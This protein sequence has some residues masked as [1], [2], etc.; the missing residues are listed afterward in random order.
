MTH[1]VAILAPWTAGEWRVV[2]PDAPEC[3]AIANSP[4]EAVFAAAVKV[5]RRVC[6][7]GIDQTTPRDLLA[8]ATD[9]AWMSRTDIDFAN[10]VVTL[11]PSGAQ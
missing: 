2:I 6:T 3:E 9:R 7:N 5:T 8:I 10:A 1:F 11:I 4:D